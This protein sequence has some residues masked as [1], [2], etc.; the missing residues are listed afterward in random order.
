MLE[1]ERI[2]GPGFGGPH[3][4]SRG[5]LAFDALTPADQA[6]VTALFEKGDVPPDPGTGDVFQYRITRRE[7]A[8]AR[9]IQVP[10]RLVP[11]ALIASVQ[12]TIE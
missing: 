3:L 9:T 10:E 2:G 1:I 11:P 12:D 4:K 7:G 5:R 8:A 6:K